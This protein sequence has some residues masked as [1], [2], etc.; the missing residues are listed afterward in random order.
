MKRNRSQRGTLAHN[1]FGY[2]EVMWFA[3]FNKHGERMWL[4][5]CI[6]WRKGR[7]CGELVAATSRDLRKGNVYACKGCSAALRAD[8]ARR[9]AHRRRGQDSRFPQAL[10]G[11]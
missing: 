7:E 10:P 6:Q 1:T 11:R 3:G 9:Q 8:E 4:T 2:L 5:K